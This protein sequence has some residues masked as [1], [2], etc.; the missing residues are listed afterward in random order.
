MNLLS[1]VPAL[2][3]FWACRDFGLQQVTVHAGN[4]EVVHTLDCTGMKNLLNISETK[5][6]AFNSGANTP[7]D[8]GNLEKNDLVAALDEFND[9]HD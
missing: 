3:V 1:S 5:D 2:K 9:A 7:Q 4:D 6:Y 8:Q